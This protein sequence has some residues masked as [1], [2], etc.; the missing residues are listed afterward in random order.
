LKTLLLDKDAWDLMVDASGNIAVASN[1]YAVAQSVA[2]ACR[3]F[4]GEAIYDI[5]L[6]VPYWEEIL[7]KHPPVALIQALIVQE[8]MKVPDV[9][10][11]RCLLS[12]FENRNIT[13]Q[14]QII[15]TQGTELNAHF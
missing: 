14:I 7:G 11:V 9:V 3:L 8:A 1:P 15:D 5:T 4:V 10:Q 13:G 2:C 12:G 6:G